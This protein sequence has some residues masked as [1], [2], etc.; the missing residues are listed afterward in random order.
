MKKKIKKTKTKLVSGFTPTPTLPLLQCFFET[1]KRLF[2][3]VKGRANNSSFCLCNKK[4]KTKLV[5]GFTLIELLVTISMFVIITGV[6]LVNSNKFD[7]SILLHNFAYDVALTIKQ[8]Q[9]YG[10]NVTENSSGTFNSNGEAY[11]VYFNT[12]TAKDSGGSTTNFVLFNDTGGD[13]SV[14]D[15]K[16]NGSFTS[17]L[18][19][20]PE[21][22]QKY[23][24]TKGTYIKSICAGT[25][26]NNCDDIDQL[27]ILFNRPSPNANIYINNGNATSELKSY[28]KIVLSALDGATS[29]VVVTSVGQIYV[30]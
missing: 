15:K 5:S 22:M 12:D 25:D 20:D 18:V 19:G 26:D 17:C 14:P 11:G 1:R 9:L 29:T 23:S 28:A 24:M 4:T 30:K 6:V 7:S 16:Y 21:C 27:S 3:Y 13:G 2:D 10:V 8:A